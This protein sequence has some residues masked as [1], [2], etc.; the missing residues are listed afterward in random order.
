MCAVTDP[1]FHRGG[2]VLR[3]PT[4]TIF[5]KFPQKL[6]MKLKE[7]RPGVGVSEIL[8]EPLKW[9]KYLVHPVKEDLYRS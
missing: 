5:F 1:G 8:D 9:T 7:V 2:G 6:H 4:L 3:G